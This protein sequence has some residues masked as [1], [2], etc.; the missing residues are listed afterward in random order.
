M[1]TKP[2]RT[3][4]RI[5]TTL[6]A[7][8]FVLIGA[9]SASAQDS[10]DG[11]A[12]TDQIVATGR[13]DVA[14]GETVGAA[15]IFDGPATI[16]GT[17][18]ETLVVF[19]GRAEISGTVREDVIVFDGEVVV[20]SGARIDGDIISRQT[21]QVA[22]GATVGGQQKS[23]TTTFDT[24]EVGLAGRIVWWI[25]YSVSTLI[26]GVLLLAF[27][28]A[29]DGAIL[30]AARERTGGSIGLGVAAFFLLPIVAVLFLA[31][32]VAIPLGLFVLLGLAL[33]YTVGY[34][35]GTHA[36]GRLIVK[37]PSSR[38]V[39]FLVGWV[40]L[41]LIALIPVAGGVVWMLVALFGLG[42]LFVAT[43]QARPAPLPGGSAMPP[44]MP[45]SA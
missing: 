45:A 5:A 29:L 30:R 26:L 42:A 44:P 7:A 21:P 25:A 39:A 23:V 22:E 38:Y 28:P 3:S 33:I 11:S 13:L 35:A 37:P 1:M 17:V 36:I 4:R 10:N 2:G 40:I 20:L 41:R 8:A 9:G 31:I 16:D 18:D 43:R 14:E 24:E 27:A 34:V 15:I 32:I 12:G 19:H 6:V